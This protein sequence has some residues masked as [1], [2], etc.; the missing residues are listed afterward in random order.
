MQKVKKERIQLSDRFTY[1]RLFRFV[2]PPI[3]MMVFTSIYSIV[4]GLFVSN[5]DPGLPF[6]ALNLIFPLI[7]I[8][9]SV[10]FM[11]GT[12]GNALVAKYLGRGEKERANKIFSLLVYAAIVFGVILSLVG[13]SVARPVAVFLCESEQDLTG[14]ERAK[15]VE[16]CVLYARIILLALPAFMLQNAFQGFFVT[17]EKPRLGLYVTLLAGLCNVV[18]DALLVPSFGLKGATIATAISQCVGGVLPVFYFLSKND[19][20]LRL[21]K[22]SCDF[23]ALGNAC[24]NG[25]SEFLTNVS[26]S[27]V[28]MFFNAQLMKFVGYN[29]V[30]AYGIIMYISFIFIAVFLGYSIGCSPI[31]GYNYGAQNEGEL[32]NIFKKSILTVT[33]G[34]V[35]MT[36]LSFA[37]AGPL[38]AIFA[39]QDKA[40]YELAVHGMRVYSF[41]F[42]LCGVS[43]FGSSLFTALSNGGVSALI[44]FMRM[45]VF[46][47]VSVLILPVF[48]EVEGIWA[49]VVVAEGLA[50]LLSVA[51]FFAFRKRYRYM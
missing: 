20:L 18:L 9:G 26:S 37:F 10:G 22:A 47:I 15:L 43:I 31:I 30:S 40:L 17:A 16:Y 5:F 33:I 12:G 44:S 28:S 6:A 38:S 25:S 46:Q 45:F 14:E 13:I 3:I 24:F 23:R 48:F 4:D 1:G 27:V 7:M 35:I 2:A 32:K 8:L 11:L 34:G 39:S 36:I 29:G 42:L 49:S 21:G 41:S 50:C 51:C 19:S